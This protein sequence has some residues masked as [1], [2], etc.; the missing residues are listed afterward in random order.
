MEAHTCSGWDRALVGT[1]T[2]LCHY[3]RTSRRL[4][5]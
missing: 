1:T 3:G 2:D 5:A 4:E